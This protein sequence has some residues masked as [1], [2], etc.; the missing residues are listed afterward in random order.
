MAGNVIVFE[1]LILQGFGPYREATTFSFTPGINGYIAANETGKTTMMAGLL[2]T[3]FGLTHRQR[4]AASFNLERFRNWNQPAACR[5]E[6][7]LS[8]AGRRYQIQR[9]FDTHQVALW[10][11][12]D[13]NGLRELLVEGQHNPEARKPLKSYEEAVRRILGI[14]SQE[15]FEATFF[16][17]Q[18]LPEVS[19]IG[20][21]LQ[22][23]LA[24]GKGAS[25]QD[26]LEWLLTKLKKLTK[27][28]GPNYRGVTARNMVKDGALEQ[29]AE[30][31]QALQEQIASGQ[32]VADSLLNIQIKVAEI[33][34]ELKKAR[35]EQE[36]KNS[37][38]QAWSGWQLLAGKYTADAK[39]RG[40]LEIAIREVSRIKEE[41]HMIE[42]ALQAQYPEFAN[43]PA[44]LS[45]GLEK[46]VYLNLEIGKAS[47]AAGKLLVSRQQGLARQEELS[48]STKDYRG[49]ERLGSDPVGKIKGLRRNAAAGL[50]AW[51]AFRSERKK[52]MEVNRRLSD[53]YGLFEAASEVEL[54]AICNSSQTRLALSAAAEK[55]EQAYLHAADKTKAWEKAQKEH[56]VKFGDLKE[57]PAQAAAA[58][59]E[60]WQLLGK[61]REL[62]KQQDPAEPK[63]APVGVRIFGG[64]VFAFVAFFMLGTGNLVM[65]GMGLLLAFLAGVAVAG[66]FYEKLKAPG[67]SK[68]Q[69][70]QRELASLKG[71]MAKCD[72]QLGSFS[73]A[74]DL[75]LARLVERLK[76]YAEDERR[77]KIIKDELAGIEMGVLEQR[78]LEKKKAGADFQ[79]AIKKFTDIYVDV[80]AAYDEWQDLAKEQKRLET[81]NNNFAESAFGYRAETAEEAG[82]NS[83]GIDEQWRYLAVTLKVLL[84]EDLAGSIKN[85]GS[86]VNQLSK[87][88][89][90]WWLER[91]EE[92]IRLVEARKEKEVLLLQLAAIGKQITEEEGKIKQLQEEQQEW[93]QNLRPVLQANENSPQL[94]LQ[95]YQKFLQQVRLKEDTNTKLVTLLNN[96][97]VADMEQLLAKYQRANDQ[98]AGQMMKWQLH[99]DKYPGLPEP[100]QADDPGAVQQKMKEMEAA[101]RAIGKNI[102]GLEAQRSELYR[103][104]A[105]LE[106]VNPINIAA[107]E[108]E[109]K[110]L[111]EELARMEQRAQ[112]LA[113]AHRELG[114]AI[115]E[116]RQTYRQRL[117][118]KAT[119]Y[120]REI[121]G[122]KDRQIVL[123]DQLNLGIKENGR[124]IATESLSK[125]ARDQVYLALRFAVADLLAGD[126]RLPLIFDDPFTGTDAARLARV[127]NILE[128]QLPNRQI[129]ILAHA[130]QYNS[131]GKAID[132]R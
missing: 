86:L 75:E 122:V 37:A 39:E 114:T 132:I 28:T 69:A 49:W 48:D 96:Y 29:L 105:R 25:F 43:A 103:Q 22:G 70:V 94:A 11:L 78:W 38:R 87:L 32:Q 95:R 93:E 18:P 71:Q 13:N 42:E 126:V 46:L 44:E 6:L 90:T 16:I 129:F 52:L 14:S 20:A 55:A 130:D 40:N 5:G 81:A 4:S 92:A 54:A 121:S 47:G 15:L 109:L 61:Q 59:A 131:W 56:L 77:L 31:I 51:E 24:G 30:K 72:Q 79:L 65:L 116:Y 12:K 35:Q 85:I 10:E 123:D 107:T 64:A 104:L 88:T 113:L 100:A 106:G 110:E 62:E 21:D 91:E 89:D 124:P 19:Q 82:L 115:T 74:D 108:V 34:G 102:S 36:Q 7:F 76:S 2:A 8:A 27:F 58:A 99:I 23:L 57:L 117:E 67:N 80:Q 50:K 84:G 127:Q 26:A 3:I 125:G 17:S 9:D 66:F 120:C 68:H 119:G 60:K 112:A 101:L 111:K 53:P 45:E 128:K 83:A 33:E 97:Q 98:A 63:K 1:K 73:Q 118:E 41:L